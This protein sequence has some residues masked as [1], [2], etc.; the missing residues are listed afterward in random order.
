LHGASEE[1]CE[2]LIPE[3]GLLALK[4]FRFRKHKP[5]RDINVSMTLTLR[6]ALSLSGAGVPRRVLVLNSASLSL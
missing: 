4:G 1:I 5:K 6:R 2:L 3:F